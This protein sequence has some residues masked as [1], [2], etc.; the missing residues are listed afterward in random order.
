MIDILT[1]GIG[2]GNSLRKSNIKSS[3]VK[4]TFDF[5][6]LISYNVVGMNLEQDFEN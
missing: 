4:S 1:I 6:F 2:G 5:N 3:K